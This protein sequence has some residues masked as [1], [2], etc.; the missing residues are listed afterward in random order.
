MKYTKDTYDSIINSVLGVQESI[1]EEVIPEWIW[2]D[3]KSFLDK[4]GAFQEREQLAGNIKGQGHAV[5]RA[6]ACFVPCA[7][8]S[9]KAILFY[10][11]SPHK[12]HQGAPACLCCLHSGQVVGVMVG[13]QLG[14]LYA[15]LWLYPIGLWLS[16]VEVFLAWHCRHVCSHSNY[17]VHLTWV[18]VYSNQ[19]GGAFFY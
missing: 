10:F 14:T 8:Q 5:L 12:T 3:K 13:A 1:L 9:N 19:G 2:Q 6:L 15:Q 17:K 4:E 18:S 11:T 7:Y 16:D